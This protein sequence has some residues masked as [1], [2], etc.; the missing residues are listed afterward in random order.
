[1]KRKLL[2]L[3]KILNTHPEWYFSFNGKPEDISIIDIYDYIQ[4]RHIYNKVNITTSDQKVIY[5]EWIYK[6]EK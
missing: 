1:M 5:S 2:Q 3:A 6:Y 4:I